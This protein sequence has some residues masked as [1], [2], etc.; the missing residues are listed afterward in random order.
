MLG[1]LKRKPLPDPQVTDRPKAWVA[2]LMEMSDRDTIMLAEL[3]C[4]DPR[5]R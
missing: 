5:W 3:A 4:R 2:G 1:L